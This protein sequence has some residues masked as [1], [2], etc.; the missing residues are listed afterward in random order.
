MTDLGVV[1]LVARFKP[2]HKGHAVMLESVCSRASK[3]YIGLGSSNK[4][5]VQNPFTASESR[6]M[7]DLV[8]K[9]K[10][11]NYSFV[12]VPDLGHGP[13]W[14]EQAKNLF[15]SLDCFVTANDYVESLLKDTYKVARPL[16]II[17]KDS[18]FCASGT[19]VRVGMAQGQSWQHLVCDLVAA[20]LSENGLV[21]RFCRE[22]GLETI[23]KCGLELV[24]GAR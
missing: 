10:F 24:G 22:F 19:M 11:S 2:V 23:A 15:G 6:D 3:V 16:D 5:D 13:R 14:R 1:G 9:S 18:Q 12:E 4:Y 7:V 21:D 8:L 17:P 20:Y